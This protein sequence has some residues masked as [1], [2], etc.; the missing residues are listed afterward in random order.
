MKLM[1]AFPRQI[2]MQVACA[3]LLFYGTAQLPAELNETWPMPSDSWHFSTILGSDDAF[4]TNSN[5]SGNSFDITV[6]EFNGFGF[7]QS[8]DLAGGTPPLQSNNILGVRWTY[9]SDAQNAEDVPDVRLRMTARDGSF[10]QSYVMQDAFYQDGHSSPNV[11]TNERDY[12]FQSF[13]DIPPFLVNGAPFAEADGYVL[14]FD[15]LSFNRTNANRLGKTL[16]LKKVEAFGLNPGDL[17]SPSNV[18]NTNF[19]SDDQGWEIS[20]THIGGQ[21]VV[22]VRN[23]RGLGIRTSGPGLPVPGDPIGYNFSYG[24]WTLKDAFTLKP[25][26]VYRVHYIVSVDSNNGTGE[27]D[28]VPTRLRFSDPKLDFAATVSVGSNFFGETGGNPDNAGKSYVAWVSFPP[29]LAVT[30]TP[31]TI[32][33]EVWQD[34]QPNPSGSS[35]F[36]KHLQI[37]EYPYALPPPQTP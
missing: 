21:E 1:P 4:T 30:E 27:T 32:Y 7:Y 37:K 15:V 16:R 12:I 3:S 25:N 33:W 9:T 8:E 24:W 20:D 2:V 23:E 5:S 6:N 28:A 36:I 13:A 11:P 22:H 19:G 10:T 31:I 18:L 35:M 29:E 34:A 17:G 26:H 14:A